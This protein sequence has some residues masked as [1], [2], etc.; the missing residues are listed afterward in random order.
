MAGTRLKI[1]L[2]VLVSVLVGVPVWWFTAKVYRPTLPFQTMESLYKERVSFLVNLFYFISPS[3]KPHSM[4][5]WKI[6]VLLF[7][8]D[9]ENAEVLRKSISL[10]M[11]ENTYQ[12]VYQVLIM[13]GEGL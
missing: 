1:L 6:G 9:I 13:E 5:R 3:F 10:K 4:K 7:F 2:I 11:A 12:S 8:E